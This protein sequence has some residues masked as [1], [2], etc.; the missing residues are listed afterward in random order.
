MTDEA[1]DYL[2]LKWGNIKGWHFQTEAA[3]A[4]AKKFASSGIPMCAME[5]L[6]EDQKVALCNLID[7]IDGEIMN[8]WSGEQMT[9]EAA[10]QYV[11]E[12]GA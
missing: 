9:K 4:A 6:N 11:M 3:L 2:S 1:K 7:A 8:D 10:K 5:R 12:Y